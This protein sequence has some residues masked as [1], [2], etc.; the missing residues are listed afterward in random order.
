M[1]LRTKKRSIIIE[2]ADATGKS[3]LASKLGVHYKIHVFHAGP[4]PTSTHH[5]ELCMMYQLEWLER[6]SCIWDR[7]TG[8]SNICNLPGLSRDSAKMHAHY[9]KKV[10]NCAAVIIC[11]AE[12]LDAHNGENYES[13]EDLKRVKIE[14]ETVS[15]NYKRMAHDLPRVI[16]YDFK[17]RTL[18][19]LIEELDHAVSISI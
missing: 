19:S 18:K 17:I 11:T 7:F 1:D 6:S 3:T 2:G 16:R 5:A 13:E 9:T 15:N 12:N 10:I 4:K 14:H 8:I